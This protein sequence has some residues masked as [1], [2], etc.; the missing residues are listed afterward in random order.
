V[1]A[2]VRSGRA[3]PPDVAILDG[4]SSVAVD[5]DDARDL[6]RALAGTDVVIHAAG[7]TRAPPPARLGLMRA[8]VGITRRVA[9][10][11]APGHA[12]LVYISSQAAAGPA[13]APNRAVREK[14]QPAPVEAYG[15]SKL[16]AE[17]AVAEE[18]DRKRWSVIR[19]VAV[20]GPRERD[21]V[22]LFRAARKGVAVHPGNRAQSIAIV[23]VDDLVRGIMSAA[24]ERSAAGKCYFV[25]NASPVT[26]SDLYRAAA[27][28]CD[29]RI[30]FDVQI[31]G[32]LVDA[33]GQLG[34]F[35]A[36]FTGKAGLLTTQKIALAK[37]AW[38][39]C[40]VEAAAADLGYVSRIPLQSG[41]R[42]TYAWYRQAGWL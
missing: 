28:A 12:T 15:A 1:R 14:D 20:Y 27:E 30:R 9:R 22:A 31:P 8:N 6:R 18:L 34:D 42:A 24:R 38:W 29:D 25:G 11:V 17:R 2:L 40:S 32:A 41:L 19:P 16:E 4:L 5:Y 10:A 39:H 36:R 26:W 33:M 13:S 21:F 37:P 3:L 7:A 23:H 35:H